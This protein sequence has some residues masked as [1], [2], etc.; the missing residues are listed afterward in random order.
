MNS[1][2]PRK[3]QLQRQ[4]DQVVNEAEW[5]ALQYSTSRPKVVC[6]VWEYGVMACNVIG[7]S[8]GMLGTISFNCAI[9]FSMAFRA[10]SRLFSIGV[11]LDRTS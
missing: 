9:V 2:Q 11:F 6:M 10:A 4:G 3:P 1:V 5:I 7:A 8:S